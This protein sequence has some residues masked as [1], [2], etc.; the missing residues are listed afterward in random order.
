MP[1]QQVMNREFC[2]EREFQRVVLFLVSIILLGSCGEDS[3]RK[4]NIFVGNRN[5]SLW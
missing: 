1:S 2:S 4:M 5:V 3:K